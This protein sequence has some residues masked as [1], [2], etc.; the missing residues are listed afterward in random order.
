MGGGRAV[1]NPPHG[2]VSIWEDANLANLA[3]AGARESFTVSFRF[4]TLDLSK[5]VTHAHVH[6]IVTP[7]EV[8]RVDPS[9][10]T[11]RELM[12]LSVCTLEIGKDNGH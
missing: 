11:G 9:E 7:T 5:T 3:C 2:K 12:D 6:H 8:V 1:G 10:D 4:F